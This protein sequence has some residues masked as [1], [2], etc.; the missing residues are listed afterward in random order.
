MVAII[1]AIIVSKVK[2]GKI[3]PMM[4]LS[5]ASVVFFGA[6][7]VW[8]HDERFIQIKPTIIYA[9]FCSAIAWSAGCAARRCSNMCSNS[10]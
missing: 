10:L 6:L 2:L 9:V 8:F 1:V 3:S 7:T 5:A 4:K